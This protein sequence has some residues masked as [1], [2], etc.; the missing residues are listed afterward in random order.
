MFTLYIFLAKKNK[1]RKI[2]KT[3]MNNDFQPDKYDNE[4]KYA[5]KLKKKPSLGKNKVGKRP[6]KLAGIRKFGHV[7]IY[8]SITS[9]RRINK[10]VHHVY[11]REL[12]KSALFEQI[13][14][15][16]ILS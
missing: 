1:R 6:R 14:T 12:R 8:S 16:A 5:N 2:K 15:T 13:Y 3:E 10:H 7:F 11:R 4:M 9:K